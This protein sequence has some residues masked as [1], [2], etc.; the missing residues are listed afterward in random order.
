[1]HT[2]GHPPTGDWI[3]VD[4]RHV[5]RVGSGEPPA[6]DRTVELPGATILPGFIDAHVHLT[7]TGLSLLNEDV[8]QAG[9]KAEL[10]ALAAQR[11]TTDGEDVVVLQGFDET[12]WGSP[13]LPS[14][15]ELDAATTLPLVIRRV[16]GHVALA[17]TAALAAAE[18]NDVTGCERDDSGD[19]TGTVTRQANARLGRWAAASRSEHR[20]EQLQLAAASLAAS[21]GVTGIHEM[22]MPHD[23]GER[24]VEVFRRHR[25]RLPVHA[26]AIVATMDVPRAIEFGHDAIGGDLPADG[27][28]GARTA[29]LS[30]P[31]AGRGDRGT[32]YYEDD[33]LAGFFHDA[34]MAG[35][36]VGM[37]A[38]GD[39]AIEQLLSAWERIYASLDS[40]ERRHFRARRHRVEHF[41][42]PNAHQ[43]ERTAMLGLAVSVQPAFDRAWGA[44]GGMYE[45]RVGAD[46]SFAMNPFRAMLDRGVVVGAGSDA[47]VTPLDPWLA[48]AAMET[49][50]DP[51]QRLGR[52]ESIR[53]HTLGSARLAHQEEK[54]GL[55]EPGY[56]ADFAAYDLDPLTLDTVE[57]L[58]PMLTVSLGRDV[59]AA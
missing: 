58:R 28:I 46:R 35:L 11:A 25:H 55:L 9:S 59:Y 22:S 57:G 47:P 41:E 18:V 8:A 5:Q 39:R 34:H 31:Y 53:V 16:D 10:L 42:M 20:I 32:T 37:H 26:L 40:R 14:I 44:A 24:D 2:F 36:Q 23:D 27:S 15:A 3:L 12:R 7:S 13:E 1:V 21:R 50:H 30:V 6:A 29:A 45:T 43:I 56:H 17:N 52:V 4:G 48:I 51:A 49:H 38:I 19:P 54:K 33:E